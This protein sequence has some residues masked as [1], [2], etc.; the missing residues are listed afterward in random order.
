MRISLTLHLQ[1]IL[2]TSKALSWEMEAIIST[3]ISSFRVC[4][5]E[6][7][8]LANLFNMAIQMCT[9][10]INSTSKKE[11]VSIKLKWNGMAHIFNLLSS[12]LTTG[13]RVSSWKL[14]KN[15]QAKEIIPILSISKKAKDVLLD[16]KV[17]RVMVSLDP[18]DTTLD[19]M[20]QSLG[21]V[22]LKE[23]SLS[24]KM[25]L[26]LS[27]KILL[28]LSQ[29]MLLLLSQKKLLQLSQKNLVMNQ[30]H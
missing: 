7:E 26:Q 14:V 19:L 9:V 21:Q 15:L 20:T 12:P 5:Q 13:S 4:I 30:A 29:K 16:S 3:I 6:M 24:Q 23:T 8:L 17:K 27:Q 11:I 28:Q 18:L 25:L 22:H 2:P 1:V 10:N